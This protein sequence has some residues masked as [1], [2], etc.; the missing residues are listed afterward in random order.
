MTLVEPVDPDG[1]GTDYAEIP[2]PMPFYIR[3]V[4]LTF[5]L[6]GALYDT[7]YMTPG[8]YCVNNVVKLVDQNLV[9][10]HDVT[11][12]VRAGM[13]LTERGV[14]GPMRRQR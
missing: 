2:A 9:S 3:A 12:F 11:F 1:E 7:I 13:P 5:H 4:T 6:N 14:I 8:V 10:G